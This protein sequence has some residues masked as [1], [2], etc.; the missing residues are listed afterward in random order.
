MYVDMLSFPMGPGPSTAEYGP[1]NYRVRI[2]T[3]DLVLKAMIDPEREYDASE[4]AESLNLREVDVMKHLRSLWKG[5]ILTRRKD[6]N[7]DRLVYRTKQAQLCGLY[8]A[9]A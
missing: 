6:P 2:V 9:Q 3:I 5:G 4:V 8:E 1:P 7:R